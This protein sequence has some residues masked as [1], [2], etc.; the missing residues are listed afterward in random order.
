MITFTMLKCPENLVVF[1]TL[2][3]NDRL[4]LNFIKKNWIK[5]P[6]PNNCILLIG[7]II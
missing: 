4:L 2:N 7:P 5:K 3:V 1:D 6:C